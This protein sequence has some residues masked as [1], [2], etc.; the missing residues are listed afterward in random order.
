MDEFQREF[1]SFV[2]LLENFYLIV[3]YPKIYR[4]CKN[5]LKTDSLLGKK[6]LKYYSPT[7]DR[8]CKISHSRKHSLPHVC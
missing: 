4:K 1:V 8:K 2:K 5:L 6:S 7:L 3:N